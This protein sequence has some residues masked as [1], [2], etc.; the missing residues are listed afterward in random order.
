VRGLRVFS[1]EKLDEGYCGN[2]ILPGFLH[3]PDAFFPWIVRGS[4]SNGTTYLLNGAEKILG[5]PQL[6]CPKLCAG[7]M[8][9]RLDNL[10]DRAA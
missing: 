5:C 1:V 6:T 3:E 2:E 7:L 10:L 8:R 9:E 4:E